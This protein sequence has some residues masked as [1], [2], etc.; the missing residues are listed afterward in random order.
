[1]RIKTTQEILTVATAFHQFCQSITLPTATIKKIRQRYQRIVKQLNKDFWNQSDSA[2]HCLYV[3]SYGRDTDIL[4]SDIDVLFWLPKRNLSRYQNRAS[5]GPSGL[6][7][8][9]KKSIERTY[10]KTSLRAD[11][12]VVV[13]A[14]G[15]KMRFEVVPCFEQ[16]DKNFIYPDSNQGGSWPKTS[17]RLEIEAVNAKDKATNGLMKNLCRMTR[18]WKQKWNVPISGLLIDTLVYNFLNQ[19]KPSSSSKVRYDHACRDFFK[20]L[21]EQNPEQNYWLALGSRQHVERTGLFEYKAK[22]CYNLAL[23]AIEKE[24]FRIAHT[25]WRQIY[26]NKFPA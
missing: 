8:D 21:S 23:E 14:F 26:G 17:P 20:F 3:G 16:T 12:Q 4:V 25:K 2:A 13:V 15:D 18:A 5:N 10:A 9:L 6:L 19:W 24:K 7:Q 22:R 1:M 11:G